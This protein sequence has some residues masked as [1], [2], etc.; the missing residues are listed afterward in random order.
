MSVATKCQCTSVF[1]ALASTW[2]EPRSTTVGRDYRDA[3]ANPSTR[4]T[5]VV[6]INS[7]F[8]VRRNDRHMA[9]AMPSAAVTATKNL[10]GATTANLV[11]LR[12]ILG[13]QRIDK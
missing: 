2:A 8:M 3:K 12:E 13:P 4:A 5:S 1:Y 6:T 7:D 10:C 11:A 9:K